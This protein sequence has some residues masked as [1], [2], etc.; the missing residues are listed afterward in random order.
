MLAAVR[1]GEALKHVTEAFKHKQPFNHPQLSTVDTFATMRQTIENQQRQAI[2]L[3]IRAKLA[4]QFSEAQAASLNGHIAEP[5]RIQFQST[6][7]ATQTHNQV[8]TISEHPVSLV[9]CLYLILSLSSS[10]SQSLFFILCLSVSVS[11]P[12]SLSFC[13]LTYTHYRLYLLLRSKQRNSRP[14]SIL[15]LIL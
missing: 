2:D 14:R 10:V 4:A 9:L 6:T 8:H 1:Q 12:L 5:N 3:V 11:H 7:P 15:M 13:T